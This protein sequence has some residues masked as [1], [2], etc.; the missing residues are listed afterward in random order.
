M[1]EADRLLGEVL[2]D[3]RIDATSAAEVFASI[4]R[5]VPRLQKL[6][7]RSTI[8]VGTTGTITERLCEFGLRAAVPNGFHKL[9]KDW[10]WIG[11]FYVRGEPFNTIITVKSFKAKERLL[12]SGTGNLLSPTIGFGLFNDPKEWSPNR[13]RSY[14]FRAFF[15]VYAPEALLKQLSNDVLRIRNINNR[16]FLRPVDRFVRDLKHAT[17][18][19]LVDPRLL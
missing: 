5:I 19:G 8:S 16:Q 15:A 18:N 6:N 12:S 10:K 14:V 17:V 11:D 2:R 7:D 9:T 13:I 3:L 1:T 4:E